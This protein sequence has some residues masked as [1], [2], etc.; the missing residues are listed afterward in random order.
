MAPRARCRG[1]SRS[2]PDPPQ[3]PPTGARSPRAPRPP[4][5]RRWLLTGGDDH[6]LAATFPPDALLPFGWLRVGTVQPAGADDTDGP[7][8][9]VDGRRYD[10]GPS[11]WDHFPSR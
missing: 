7:A 8:V 5:P 9:L 10:G 4:A 11:G 2:G 1:R 3:T 6:A